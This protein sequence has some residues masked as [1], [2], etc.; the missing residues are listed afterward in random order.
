M[1]KT[2]V[3]THANDSDIEKVTDR[4]R[5]KKL[6][7]ATLRQCQRS[8]SQYRQHDWSNPYE[9]LT[10]WQFAAPT[11]I[12]GNVSDAVFHLLT[13]MCTKNRVENNKNR[14]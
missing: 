11:G 9:V 6:W 1:Y 7:R 3:Y 8:A 10:R 13:A 14:S 12:H 4:N 2:A 5:K